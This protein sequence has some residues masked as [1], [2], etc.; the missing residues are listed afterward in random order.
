MAQTLDL[1]AKERL[2]RRRE[3]TSRMTGDEIVVHNPTAGRLHFLNR[4]ATIVWQACD[5]ATTLD[6]CLEQIRTRCEIP[7]DVR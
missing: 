5:G 3:L 2:P 6:E 4:T 7:A 1:V